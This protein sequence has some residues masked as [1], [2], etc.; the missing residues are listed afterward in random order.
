MEQTNARIALIPG[1]N[2]GVGFEIARQLGKSG[3]RVLLGARDE[4]LGKGR[5]RRSAWRCCR[6]TG[7]RVA[8]SAPIGRSP[9]RSAHPAGRSQAQL[10]HGQAP[11]RRPGDDR[12]ICEPWSVLSAR[13]QRPSS[14][15]LNPGRQT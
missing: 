7:R 6:T 8:S 14:R 3:M 5:P 9:W 1:A 11:C 15:S 4:T 2:K 13:P 10:R 12:Q